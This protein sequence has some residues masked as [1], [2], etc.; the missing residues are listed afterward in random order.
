MNESLAATAGT[1]PELYI[2]AQFSHD[3][4][5]YNVNASGAIK[6]REVIAELRGADRP[7]KVEQVAAAPKPKAE[8]TASPPAAVASSQPETAAA[9]PASSPEA[10]PSPAAVE[11]SVLQKAVFTLA[12]KSREAAAAVAASFG[13]KTFKELDATR[14]AEALAAVNAKIAEV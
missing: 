7:V 13:V 8:K 5:S 10:S 9:S 3:G 12:G 6:I 11:Y 1:T 4:V 14:W 2:H